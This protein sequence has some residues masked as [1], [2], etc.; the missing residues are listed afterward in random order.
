MRNRYLIKYSLIVLNIL[1]GMNFVSLFSIVW[2]ASS[3][4]ITPIMIYHLSH[5]S[6][7]NGTTLELSY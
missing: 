3:G 5:Q 2:N 1:F 7:S 6:L 4:S